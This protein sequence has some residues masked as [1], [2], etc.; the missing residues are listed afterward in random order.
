MTEVRRCAPGRFG[1]SQGAHSISWKSSKNLPVDFLEHISLVIDSDNNEDLD[2]VSIMTLH[3]AK[4]LEFETVS[5]LPGW[6]GGLF[7]HQRSLDE[8]EESRAW[9]RSDD[10]PMWASPEHEGQML[11][12][13]CIQPA[14]SRPCGRPPFHHDSLTSYRRHHVAI[15]EAL[16]QL[17]RIRQPCGCR[18]RLWSQPL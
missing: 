18:W 2:A 15:N 13:V 11:H 7:P 14:Y 12:L 17:W 16:L 3:S 6:E 1:K 10:W 4:G 5:S 8:S 9:K